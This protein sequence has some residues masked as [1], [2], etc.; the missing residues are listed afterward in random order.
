MQSPTAWTDHPRA[1]GEHFDCTC[2]ASGLC[3]SSPR[4]RGT[5]HEMQRGRGLVRII[6]APAGNTRKQTGRCC[7]DSDHPR[8]CGEHNEP[9]AGFPTSGGIIP[10]PAGNTQAGDRICVDAIGSSP[11]LRGTHF[12]VARHP[13]RRRIIPAPAGNTALLRFL[14]SCRPDHPRACGEHMTPPSW[15]CIPGGSS[16]RLRGTLGW[17]QSFPD[18]LRIIPAPA[19][20]T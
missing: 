14:P 5:P 9:I 20:N 13:A 2:S 1:C 11:R 19:G 10:A 7:L 15:P 8:A 12:Q 4:L 3:G 18:K 16:P 6:P 17:S